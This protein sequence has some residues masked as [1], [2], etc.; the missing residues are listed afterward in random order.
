[1]PPIISDISFILDSSLNIFTEDIATVKLLSPQ[2]N[3]PSDFGS[4][5]WNNTLASA[6]FK[7]ANVSS[8]SAKASVL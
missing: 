7:L 3:E 2:L 1:M 8:S 4:S 6:G 5:H